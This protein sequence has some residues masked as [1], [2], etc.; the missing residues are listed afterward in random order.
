MSYKKN[1]KELKKSPNYRN[2]F[3]F[4]FGQPRISYSSKQVDI[5]FKNGAQIF[6]SSSP[7]PNFTVKNKNY[8]HRI[9]LNNLND[10]NGKIWFNIF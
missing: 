5:L 9:S 2:M 8:L 10:R 6:F 1:E 3:A 7:T 4:P